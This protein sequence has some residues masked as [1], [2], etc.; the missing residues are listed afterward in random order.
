MQSIQQLEATLA[1]LDKEYKEHE[2]HERK[3][4]ENKYANEL[5][6][7]LIPYLQKADDIIEEYTKI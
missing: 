1:I 2:K 5:R 4:R 6:N 7:K 3:Q